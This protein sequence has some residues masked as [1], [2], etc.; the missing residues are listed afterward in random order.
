[1]TADSANEKERWTEGW[2]VAADKKLAAWMT[3]RNLFLALLVFSL[4]VDLAFGFLF[5][6]R[7]GPAQLE[8]DELEYYDMASGLMAGTFELTARRTL[9]Y[10]L[11]IAGIRSAGA[12]FL[13]L[14]AAIA[15]LFSFSAPLLSEVVRKVTG[16]RAAGA[17]AGLILAVWPP[18]V[19]YGVSLYSEALAL[20][21]FLLAL[22]ALPA[23]S[24]TGRPRRRRG[25]MMTVAA[26]LLLAAATQVRPMYL[27][28]TPFIALILFFE[29]SD[30]R[31]ALRRLVLVALAF[32]AAMLPWSAYMTVRF[33]HP[34]LVT[35]NG[36]E[37]MAGG[38]NPKLLEPWT[39][40]HVLTY[41]RKT[42][43]G[44]GKW[45]PIYETGYLSAAELSLPYDQQ[46][47]LL[48]ERA[49]AWIK[50]HPGTA[51]HLE[52]C[53]LLY[54]WGF[55]PFLKNGWAQLF[56]GNI[57]TM[58]LL[59]ICLF[60]FATTP[61]ARTALARF[62]I[63]PVFVTVVAAISWGSWRF[64]QPG[65]AGLIAFCVI[66]LLARSAARRGGNSIAAANA[67]ETVTAG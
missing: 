27:I 53:K 30:W 42:W 40:R 43:V 12:S 31:L 33:H 17:L 47:A 7:P 38:L 64:R 41:A 1:M 54:M 14:Q 45:L 25:W 18:V 37:T 15:A 9:A 56:L 11:L 32:T 61:A 13:L 20:P 36:G 50:A 67:R 26:G 57:P 24:R 39:Q 23:G 48:K 65:D 44:P 19:F 2:A 3:P 66:C 51:F 21:V 8:A 60:C 59:S 55:Y 28:M 63:L 16:S 29:E 58:A 6:F 46:D 22:W 34:I 4:V 5:R 35:S 49:V 52:A 62:W 10:P